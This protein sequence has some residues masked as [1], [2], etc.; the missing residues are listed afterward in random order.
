MVFLP[1]GAQVSPAHETSRSMG[2]THTGDV[3]INIPIS[4]AVSASEARAAGAAAA[5][6]YVQELRRLKKKIRD[7]EYMNVGE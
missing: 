3:H 7:I 4:G 6:G 2:I 1:R 5:D